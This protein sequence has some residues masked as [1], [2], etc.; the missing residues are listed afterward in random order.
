MNENGHQCYMNKCKSYIQ[1][2]DQIQ[3]GVDPHKEELSNSSNYILCYQ[4]LN[5]ARREILAF[6]CARRSY[7][8]IIKNW[9]FVHFSC[10]FWISDWDSS[11]LI[12]QI[13][14][15]S[16]LKESWVNFLVVNFSHS[17]RRCF[18]CFRIIGRFGWRMRWPF[19]V[20]H[21]CRRMEFPQFQ[22]IAR[23]VPICMLVFIEISTKHI[24]WVPNKL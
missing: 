9:K 20:E 15:N 18:C 16:L 11:P 23:M 10:L 3:C 2:T 13:M 14:I 12:F 24:H 6:L 8:K 5:A 19:V 22:H 7:H 17:C 4:H 21:Y 1:P